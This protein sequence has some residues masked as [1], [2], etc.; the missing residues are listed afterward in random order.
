[1]TTRD[2]LTLNKPTR[3]LSFGNIYVLKPPAKCVL[4]LGVLELI[5]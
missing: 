4:V 2:R 5:A 1:M 3:T